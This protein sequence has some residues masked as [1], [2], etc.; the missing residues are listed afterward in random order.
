MLIMSN[1]RSIKTK[2]YLYQQDIQGNIL[3]IID[4]NRKVMVKY[5]QK[6]WDGFVDD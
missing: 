1:R 5:K 6:I 4:S 2:T 3:A